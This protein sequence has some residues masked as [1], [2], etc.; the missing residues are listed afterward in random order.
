MEACTA[1]YEPPSE[2]P[3]LRYR[4]QTSSAVPNVSQQGTNSNKVTNEVIIIDASPEFVHDLFLMI[5]EHPPGQD[6]VVVFNSERIAAQ[7]A[8]FLRELLDQVKVG[9]QDKATDLLYDK[10]HDLLSDADHAA[11]DEIMRQAT[12]N[13]HKLTTS[14]MRSFL[15]LT[16]KDRKFLQYRPA[17]YK[18][19]H[20]E[21]LRRQDKERT[22]RLLGHLR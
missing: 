1:T 18:R 17:F 13:T 9:D 22:D 15:S 20:A 3:R 19:A 16:F 14:L 11:C 4:Q 6:G 5:V 7:A 12:F 8:I 10:F 21:T 2:K